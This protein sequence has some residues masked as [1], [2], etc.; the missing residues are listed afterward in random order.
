MNASTIPSALVMPVAPSQHDSKIDKKDRRKLQLSED[1]YVHGSEDA[2]EAQR[3]AVYN[4][5]G[6]K[7]Q[8]KTSR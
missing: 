5:R 4:R 1:E 3:A 2:T 8:L 6:S 7:K